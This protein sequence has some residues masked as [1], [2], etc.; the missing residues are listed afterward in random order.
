ML[1]GKI[2]GLIRQEVSMNL[3]SGLPGGGLP[4]TV[5]VP[6]GRPRWPISRIIGFGRF[7]SAP[8]IS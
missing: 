1:R 4:T 3:A 7:P 8:F 5:N 2:P 6:D